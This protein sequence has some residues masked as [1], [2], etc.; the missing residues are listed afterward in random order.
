MFFSRV[1]TL[2]IGFSSPKYFSATFVILPEGTDKTQVD[3]KLPGFIN[4]YWADSQ[5]EPIEMYLFPFLDIRLKSIHIN[6]FMANSHQAAT[7]I[8]FFIGTLLLIIVSINYI[9]L[10]TA[11]SMYRNREIGIRKV[12]GARR[13]QL[14]WQFLGESLIMSF[15]AVPFSIIFYEL[16]HPYFT[17]YIA[18]T[19]NIAV[20]S[21]SIFNYPFLLKYLFIASIL[22]GLFSG[23]YP[24]FF[25]SKFKPVQVLKGNL[26]SGRKKTSR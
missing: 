17:N 1:K 3:E 23:I 6:S 9:N 2:P 8:F 21:N 15:I 26:K 12:I 16:L 24:A 10:S 14:I 11:R 22:T 5:K 7:F 20:V 4:K 13:S 25:L 18:P 19:G